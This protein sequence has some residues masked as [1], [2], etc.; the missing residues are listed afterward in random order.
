MVLISNKQILEISGKLNDLIETQWLNQIFLSPAWFF[1]VFLI[2]FTYVLFF[3]LVDKR[4]IIEILLF[5]SLVAV[6]FSVYDAI[7]EQLGYWATLKR[8]FPIHPNFFLG[9]LT[10]I[11]LTAM[12]VYQY[13]FS[14][15]RFLV[16]IT[17]WA[18]FLAFIFFDVV[19]EYLNIF[20]YIKKFSST[21]DFLLFLI[22]GIIARGI[23]VLL[24]KLE[25][26]RKY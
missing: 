21:I 5:G 11:P 15:R 26:R 7:G 25:G 13:A 20:V 6:A 18:G 23:M 3:F 19:L 9:D 12:L 22:V 1:H 2:L 8:V 16:W 17:V 10:L 24:L 4:R 14:W